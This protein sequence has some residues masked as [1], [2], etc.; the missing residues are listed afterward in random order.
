[1]C[2]GACELQRTVRC[3]HVCV[4][5]FHGVTEREASWT[6]SRHRRSSQPPVTVLLNYS[7]K[8]K[9]L[10]SRV[11]PGFSRRTTMG[12]WSHAVATANTFSICNR[13]LSA[14]L[15]TVGFNVKVIHIHPRSGDILECFEGMLHLNGWPAFQIT[16][17]L[18]QLQTHDSGS[19]RCHLLSNHSLSFSLRVRWHSTPRCWH[20]EVCLCIDPTLPAATVRNT[21]ARI[22]AKYPTHHLLYTAESW[23]CRCS[24]T[25]LVNQ[26]KCNTVVKWI[27]GYFGS[28]ISSLGVARLIASICNYKHGGVLWGCPSYNHGDYMLC[29]G[30]TQ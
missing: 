18:M 13:N 17:E 2:S 3:V 5:V 22:C 12:W 4:C 7:T 10:I 19:N 23:E 6:I 15:F 9:R 16:W 14:C 30:G 24:P 26:I 21:C 1:M 27:S 28:P 8:Q 29:K 25:R 11:S 20:W